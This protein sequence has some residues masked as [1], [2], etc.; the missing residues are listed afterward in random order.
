MP[1][2]A[3]PTASGSCSRSTTTK[4]LRWP[5]SAACWESPRAGCARSTPKRSSSSAADSRTRRADPTQ[6]SSFTAHSVDDLGMEVSTLRDRRLVALFAT[7]VIGGAGVAAA[8]VSLES[9]P[10]YR[11]PAATEAALA[12]QFPDSPA[13]SGTADPA[14]PDPAPVVVAVFTVDPP[15]T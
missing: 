8:A 6:R 4:A 15:A 2:T 7:L 1:S 12:A 10:G 11:G 5:R 3:C 14:P 13:P 9:G